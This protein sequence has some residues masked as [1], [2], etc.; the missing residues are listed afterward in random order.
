MHPQDINIADYDYTL[1]AEKIAQHPPEK[2]DTSKLLIYDNGNIS[3]TQFLHLPEHLPTHTHLVFNNTK[4]IPA[5]LFFQKPTGGLIELFCLEPAGECTGNIALSLAQTE[6]VQWHCMV[7]GAKKWTENTVLTACHAP[8]RLH[9][10]A[11]LVK[12]T[13]H[14][15]IIALAWQGGSTFAQV[16]QEVGNIP[17][18]PYI[19]REPDAADRDR[20][21]S[22]LAQIQGSVAAPTASLHFTPQVLADLALKHIN[23]TKVTLHVGAGTFMPVK[24]PSLAQHTMHHE[25][26]SVSRQS[27]EEIINRLPTGIV[28][29][30]TTSLRTLETLFW[31][32]VKILT[33]NYTSLAI[34][35]WDAYHLS[36]LATTIAPSEAL[37][38]L[39]AYMHTHSLTHY[40]AYT[41][42]L[43]APPYRIKV[44]KGLITNFHQPS[45]T[46]LLLVAAAIGN[47][48]RAVY[49]Y[50]LNHHFKFLS[51]GDATLLWVSE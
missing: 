14:S 44:A 41:Q 17:L 46:L 39:L 12:Q 37:L 48:W 25:Y 47:N 8:A 24:A 51:Y 20:Y 9:L 38:A 10:T 26:I 45:S 49:H 28:A 30:G 22:V 2:R 29:V 50:A 1:P 21:Q 5:R 15:Y 4:V 16:L 19:K 33:Q 27:L 32:G 23:Y 6:C 11:T 13:P 42:L 34:A 36:S 40:T 43:I 31:T 35:Q 3:E 7:G 18:P